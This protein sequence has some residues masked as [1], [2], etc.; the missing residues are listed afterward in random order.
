MTQIAPP[1]RAG[2]GRDHRAVLRLR[3]AGRCGVALAKDFGVE[4]DALVEIDVG[5]ERCGVRPARR[6]RARAPHRG[7]AEPEIPRPAGLSRPR[8]ASADP[9]AA[10][11]GDRSA[12]DAVRETL[13]ALE[14]ENLACEIVAGAGTGTFALEAESG[15]YNEL[16]VGSYVFMDTDYAR[17]AARTAGSYRVRAQPL[18]ARLGDQHADGRARHRRRGAQILQRREGPPWVH[19]PRVWR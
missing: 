11:P 16:Q 6:R 8:A 1:R 14:A 7:C 5:M 10:R 15:V 18:R 12:V 2:E 9:S 3:R 19:G 17:T 4:L 13:D